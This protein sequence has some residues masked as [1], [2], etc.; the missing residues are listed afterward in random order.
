MSR[1]SS[2][3]MHQEPEN[4]KAKNKYQKPFLIRQK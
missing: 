3:K 2:G 1:K 4:L